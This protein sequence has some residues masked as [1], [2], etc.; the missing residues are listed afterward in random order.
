M[1]K[2]PTAL[3]AAILLAACAET[4]AP[5][6]EP[7]EVLLGLN[8]KPATLNPIPVD[9]PATAAPVPGFGSAPFAELGSDGLLVVI[10][11]GSPP[12]GEGRLSIV[13]PVGRTEVASFAGIGAVPGNPASD[14]DERIFISSRTEG[15]MA[16]DIHT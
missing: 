2:I 1:T 16:F 13:D 11:P 10:S 4:K 12:P 6:P 8:H 14:G 7:V 5:L 9:D 15:L 3:I